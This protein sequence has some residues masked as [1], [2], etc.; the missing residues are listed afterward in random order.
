MSEEAK[1]TVF[2]MESYKAHKSLSGRQVYDLFQRNGVFDYLRDFYDV[3]HTT[4]IST[5]TAISTPIC[6]Q[7]IRF[8][9]INPSL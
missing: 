9:K 2:C 8:M 1:F 7:E 6:A 3:L 5:S 4:G